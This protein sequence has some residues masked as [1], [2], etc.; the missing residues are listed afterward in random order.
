MIRL[1]AAILAFGMLSDD[2]IAEMLIDVDA[3]MTRKV[4]QETTLEDLSINDSAIIYSNFCV[5]DNRLYILGWTTPTNLATASYSATGVT[6]KAVVLPGKRL[7]ITY[8]DAAQAQAV[9]KG[10]TSAPPVLSPADYKRAVREDVNRIFTG[11][12]FSTET[13]D[14]E[15]RRNPLQKLALFDIESINGQTSISGLLK[16]AEGQ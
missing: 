10:N 1:A 16:S 9:A 5:K 11:G 12:L 2:A 8:V 4:V 3:D 15:Q 13:C 6:L 14:D 7:K